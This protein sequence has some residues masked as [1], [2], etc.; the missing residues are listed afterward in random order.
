MPPGKE[1]PFCHG[2]MQQGATPV[3]KGMVADIAGDFIKTILPPGSVRWD[4][5]VCGYYAYFK[6]V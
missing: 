5:Q 6:P 2:A 3:I 4:C 1:C